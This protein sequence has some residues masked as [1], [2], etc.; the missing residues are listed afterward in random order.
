[1][2]HVKR[3]Y[4]NRLN[5]VVEDPELAEN[6]DIDQNKIMTI[7]SI[8]YLFKILRLI[9]LILVVSYFLGILFYIFCDITRSFESVQL[10]EDDFITAFGF[11]DQTNL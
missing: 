9:I 2:K 11:L 5:K 4:G 3:F 8:S 7:I 10:A 6:I 1:M